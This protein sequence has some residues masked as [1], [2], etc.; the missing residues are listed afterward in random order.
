MSRARGTEI[1]MMLI[2]RIMALA[3]PQDDSLPLN[4]ADRAADVFFKSMEASGGPKKP[5]EVTAL[6][7]LLLSKYVAFPS[8]IMLTLLSH[9]DDLVFWLM[10]GS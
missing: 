9:T 7:R 2:L 6:Q 5:A 1:F 3:G 8:L 4:C 10:K